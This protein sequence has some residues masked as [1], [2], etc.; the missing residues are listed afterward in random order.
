[1]NRV[2]V[3][4]SSYSVQ[5]GDRYS[6]SSI[7]II[8]IQ[9]LES[10]QGH[11]QLWAIYHLKSIGIANMRSVHIIRQLNYGIH[12]PDLPKTVEL[13]QNLSSIYVCSLYFWT[14]Q[15]NI[16]TCIITSDYD[17]GI[18]TTCTYISQYQLMLLLED[19]GSPWSGSFSIK[20]FF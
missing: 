11:F 15:H 12:W 2:F 17:K 13:Y 6:Y 18:S 5:K 4:K 14:L 10:V 7:I 20:T 1:M 16:A 3:Q 8:I 19:Q 9:T